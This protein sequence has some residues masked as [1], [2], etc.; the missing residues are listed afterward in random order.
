MKIKSGIDEINWAVVLA[1]TNSVN[2]NWLSFKGR[3]DDI[4]NK[5]IPHN[6]KKCD[7]QIKQKSRF[8]NKEIGQAIKNKNRL[9]NKYMKDKIGKTIYCTQ[10]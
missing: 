4:I 5:F 9:W 2:E 6:I 3:I 1:T 7:N 10:K 8:F